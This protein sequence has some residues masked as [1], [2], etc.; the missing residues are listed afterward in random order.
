MIDMKKFETPIMNVSLFSVENIVT[1][2]ADPAEKQLA[3]DA[4]TASL[5]NKGLTDGKVFELTF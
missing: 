5:K 4:A 3:V 2:S 1:G